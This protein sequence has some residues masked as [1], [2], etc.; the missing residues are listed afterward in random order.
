LIDLIASTATPEALLNFRPSE[1]NQ[2]RVSE[3]IEGQHN[4]S[5]SGE[6]AAELD[7]FVQLEHLVIMAKARARQRLAGGGCR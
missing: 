2:R 7:D 4:G 6:E 1:D 3:L 5:L